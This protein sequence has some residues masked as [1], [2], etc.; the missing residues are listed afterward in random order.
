MPNL[1]DPP[2]VVGNSNGDTPHVQGATTSSTS[3]LH[4]EQEPFS[5]NESAALE[6][7]SAEV[8]LTPELEKAGVVAHHDNV[9]VSPEVQQMGVETMG[10]TQP[11][12]YTGAV[13][14]PLTD[15][16]IVVGLH[17][18]ILSSLRWLAEWCI[19]RLKQVHVHLKNI[20]GKAVRE[21]D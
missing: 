15:D 20:G 18:Q 14:L 19:K 7:G 6:Q 4:K 5:G 11:V 12:I 8:E 1:P 3:G 10:P 2:Q 16:Q 21:V 17:A 13:Q 9:R